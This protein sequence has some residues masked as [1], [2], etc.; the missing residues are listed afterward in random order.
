MLADIFG[1]NYGTTEMYRVSQKKG[2]RKVLHEI[3]LHNV[4]IIKTKV[5]LSIAHLID[6][7]AN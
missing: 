6:K 3:V 7:K 4:L 1:R 2:V 5:Q